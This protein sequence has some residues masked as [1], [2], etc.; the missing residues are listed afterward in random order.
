M[1]KRLLLIQI[2]DPKDKMLEHEAACVRRKFEGL[3]VELL[4]VN[5]VENHIEEEHLKGVDGVVIGGSGDFSVHHPLSKGFVEPLLKTLDLLANLSVPTFGIC[6]GHQLI[7]SWLGSEV[8]TD[9][10]RAELGTVRVKKTRFGEHCEMLNEFPSEFAVHS[11]HSDFVVEAPE[12]T[13]VILSNDTVLTQA[14]LV[15]GAPMVSVQFHPDMTGAEARSRLLAYQD[16]FT[17]RI[18]TDAASFA[19]K[20]ELDADE[21][22]QLLSAFFRSQGFPLKSD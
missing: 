17:D 4:S 18:E 22:T 12:G 21:S 2:R 14:F 1:N 5:A 19:M 9:P 6:F 10:G 20:F 11:G 16:G 8:R 13:Q 3:A 15:N 7:G